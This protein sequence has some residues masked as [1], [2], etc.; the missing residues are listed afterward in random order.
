MLWQL[1]C[2]AACDVLSPLIPTMA[3]HTHSPFPPAPNQCV[4][5]AATQVRS[6]LPSPRKSKGLR[7]AEELNI[8]TAT[9][10]Q[11]APSS[12]APKVQEQIEIAGIKYATS[13]GQQLWRQRWRRR[14]A[15]EGIPGKALDWG[16]WYMAA[17]PE[18]QEASREGAS[19]ERAAGSAV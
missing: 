5:H 4:A 14:R 2:C 11:Q 7:L 8:K 19:S 6:S 16:S 12:S 10:V 3:S 13:D 15:R 18:Q 1:P 9:K 17:V